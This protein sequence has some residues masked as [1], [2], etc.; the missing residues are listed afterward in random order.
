[1]V[2]G[3]MKGGR[4]GYADGVANVGLMREGG[5]VHQ[6]AGLDLAP[7]HHAIAEDAVPP[8]ACSRSDGAVPAHDCGS[9]EGGERVHGRSLP[10]VDVP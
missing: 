3:L 7:H 5:L 1:M 10:D 2:K 4:V 8:H 9:A 6:N